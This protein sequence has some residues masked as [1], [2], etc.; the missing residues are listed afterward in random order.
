MN[1]QKKKIDSNVNNAQSLKKYDSD[2]PKLL[3]KFENFQTETPTLY[4]KMS[5]LK[6]YAEKQSKQLK[7]HRLEQENIISLYSK[8]NEE[9]S[10]LMFKLNEM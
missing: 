2:K 7:Q 6:L 5:F 1:F 4:E 8:K 3:Q 9:F 10:K